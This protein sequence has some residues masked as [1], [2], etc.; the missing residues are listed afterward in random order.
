MGWRHGSGSR[1]PNGLGRSDGSVPHVG[2]LLADRG[3]APGA[4]AARTCDDDTANMITDAETCPAMQPDMASTAGIHARLA[5]PGPTPASARPR[6]ARTPQGPPAKPECRASTG[7]AGRYHTLL[8]DLG[9][10]A[11]TPR[12]CGPAGGPRI[13]STDNLH[14]PNQQTSVRPTVMPPPGRCQK[15]DRDRHWL[16]PRASCGAAQRRAGRRGGPYPRP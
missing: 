2:M 4:G 7:P 6:P 16:S 10:G 3:G 11:A 13:R 14:L 15:R 1:C 8:D 5:G 12:P 9:A